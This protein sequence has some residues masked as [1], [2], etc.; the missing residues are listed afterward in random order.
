MKFLQKARNI[1][2]LE[3]KDENQFRTDESQP[4]EK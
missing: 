1:C 2:L 4:P 3:I